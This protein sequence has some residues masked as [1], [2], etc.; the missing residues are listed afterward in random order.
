MK[1]KK[2]ISASMVLVLTIL[3]VSACGQKTTEDESTSLAPVTLNIS[4]ASSLRE[5]LPEIIELYTAEHPNVTFIDTYDASGVLQT[6]I[7]EGAPC[8][9]FISAAS[10]QMNVLNDEGLI[11]SETI[12]KL[13]K[14]KLVLIVPK[15][16]TLEIESFEDV[17]D[18]SVG[19][20]TM[21]D[22]ASVPVGQYTQTVLKNLG[23]WEA[24]SA[25]TNYGTNVANV[26]AW[27]ESGDADCGFVYATDAASSDKVK[28]VCEA[29]VGS[30]DEI[31]YPA[32]VIK[33]SLNQDTAKDFIAF[34]STDAAKEIFIKYGFEMYAE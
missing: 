24:V 9:I 11:S 18:P 3:T 7:E 31:I 20:V 34:L 4:A 10:K 19:V 16:S 23:I 32:G 33:A 22:I 8:D 28:V 15:E 30:A 2:I 6:Q 26:L 25:K 14:G 17:T 27:V 5:A 13:L 21:G 29:P 1:I 12:V